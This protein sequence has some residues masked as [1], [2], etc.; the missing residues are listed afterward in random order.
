MRIALPHHDFV[1]MLAFFF[2]G[3][4][5]EVGASFVIHPA[6]VAVVTVDIDEYAAARIGGTQAA[7]FSRKAA[8]DHRMDYAQARAGQHGD[9]QFRDHGHVDGDA[10]AFLQAGKFAQYRRDFIHAPVQFLIRDHH[11]V[12][13]FRFGNEDERS[14]VL[15][16]GQVPVHAVVA[17]IQFAADE[18]LPEWRMIAV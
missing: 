3:L 14:L 13:V 6:A 5:R 7:G 4:H 17:G 1:N 8:E 18:P 2:G 10:V 9:G 12:L 16:L 15:V 11:V